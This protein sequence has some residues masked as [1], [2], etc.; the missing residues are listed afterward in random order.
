MPDSENS[1]GNEEGGL[2][3]IV[4]TADW[5]GD[6][7]GVDEDAPPS[8]YE[9]ML[10]GREY[11]TN[12]ESKKGGGTS[13]KNHGIKRKMVN[14]SGIATLL[15]EDTNDNNGKA[16][17]RK[18]LAEYSLDESWS[19]RLESKD[20]EEKKRDPG[21]AAL[22]FIYN[23]E[24]GE[25]FFEKKPWS[26]GYSFPGNENQLALVGGHIEPGELPYH[27]A[28]REVFEEV[29][30]KAARIIVKHIDP[31]PRYVGIEY[32]DGVPV[33]NV[34]FDAKI[35]LEE[36]DAVRFG[37]GIADAG[38][39]VIKPLEEIAAS[40]G[41]WAFYHYDIAMK[42]LSQLHYPTEWSKSQGIEFKEAYALS[43][44]LNPL[45]IHN[46][47]TK[48]SGFHAMTEFKPII[49]DDSIIPRHAPKL[50]PAF[51]R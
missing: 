50:M 45:G 47:S 4:R 3:T 24:T 51:S 1:G 22:V 38:D 7:K 48:V 35:P 16:D 20:D 17:S 29:S 5:Q 32:V 19:D 12:K 26:Y 46:D 49:Y 41:K 10:K 13:E 30:E 36:W 11:K 40:K 25:G 37:H 43:K 44:S 8:E 34:V 18:V 39:M 21:H 31:N 9:A 33:R 28:C 14:H 23:E 6:A 42:F 27:A 2:D 15:T